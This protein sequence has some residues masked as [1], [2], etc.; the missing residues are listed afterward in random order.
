MRRVDAPRR[1]R[2]G[3]AVAFALSLLLSLAVSLAL[4]AP[5][6][7]QTTAPGWAFGHPGGEVGLALGSA[8]SLSTLLLPQRQGSWGPSMEGVRDDD[9][10]GIS[11]VTGNVIGS[12]LLATTSFGLE[13]SH[14]ERY[15]VPNAGTRALRTSLIDVEAFTLS[16]GITSALK[17][18]VGRCRPRAYH[19]GRCGPEP[20][21]DAFPSGHAT[22]VAALA[23]VQLTMALRSDPLVPHRF[24]LFGVAEGMSLAT[25]TLRVLAAAHSWEDVVVGLAIGH[26]SGALVQ[27]AH[28]MET[29][30]HAPGSTAPSGMRAPLFLSYGG[31]F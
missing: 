21:H 13:V 29:V 20:E 7:A 17:A 22:P 8:L 11:D 27:L 3:G 24:A 23:G 10:G 15:G 6:Q 25:A 14:Y 16:I 31:R 26:L 18:L 1:V 9:F 12:G 19:D 5:A 28:P 2:A 30:G 4:A